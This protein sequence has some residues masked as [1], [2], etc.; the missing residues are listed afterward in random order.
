MPNCSFY[1]KLTPDQVYSSST[2]VN[3]E[4]APTVSS[5]TVN[6]CVK[7]KGDDGAHGGSS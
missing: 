5:D 7:S 3:G 2:P 1:G 6:K 4:T